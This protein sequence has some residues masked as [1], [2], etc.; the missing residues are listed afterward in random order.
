M[1]RVPAVRHYMRHQER[2]ADNVQMVPYL[3]AWKGSDAPATINLSFLLLDALLLT[4]V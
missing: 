1:F 2:K 3:D 4:L